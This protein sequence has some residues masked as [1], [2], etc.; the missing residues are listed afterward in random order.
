VIPAGAMIEPQLHNHNHRELEMIT[1]NDFTQHDLGLVRS[2]YNRF[3]FIQC[4]TG[5]PYTLSEIRD[6]VADELTANAEDGIFYASPAEFIA[7]A[8]GQFD[9]AQANGYL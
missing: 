7:A 2:L 9:H 3:G 5:Q 6:E 1:I 4:R 8:E